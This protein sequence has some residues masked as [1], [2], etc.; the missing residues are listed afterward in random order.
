MCWPPRSWPEGERGREGTGFLDVVKTWHNGIN[1]GSIPVKFLV[2]FVSEEG[3]TN[4]NR[5]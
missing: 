1:L 4:L 2:V 3:K 5:P